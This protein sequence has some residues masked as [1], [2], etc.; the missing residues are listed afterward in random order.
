MRRGY[1]M[2]QHHAGFAATAAQ[3]EKHMLGFD[4]ARRLA[5]CAGWLLLLMASSA[6][7][8][9]WTVTGSG[10]PAAAN[11]NDCS[12][13]NCATLRGA[14][15]AAQNGDTIQFASA[16][17]GSTITLTLGTLTVSQSIT[18]TGPGAGQLTVSGNNAV[19]VFHI[20]AVGTVRISGLKIANGKAPRGGAID[21]GNNATLQLDA[22]IIANNTSTDTGGGGGGLNAELGSGVTIT[23]STF[24]SNSAS[25]AGGAILSSAQVTIG[26]TTFQ[27]NRATTAGGAISNQPT[28]TLSVTNST[29]V[30]NEAA[31]SGAIDNQHAPITIS[32]STFSANRASCCYAGAIENYD[33]NLTVS[34]SIFSSNTS[35]NGAGAVQS[36]GGGTMDMANSAYNLFYGNKNNGTEDDTTGYGTA[37]YVYT[38]TAPLGALANNGGPTQ[39]ML[40]V[41]GSAAIDR[42]APGALCPSA[43]QRGGPRPQ[44]DLCDIGAVEVQENQLTL[45]IGGSGSVVATPAPNGVSAFNPCSGSLCT[46]WYSAEGS[47][48]PP[49]V[50]LVATAAV[51]NAIVGWNGDCTGTA[52]SASVTMNVAHGCGV[53]FNAYTVVPTTLP[54][55]TYGSPYAQSLTAGGAGT[56][57][58]TLQSGSS[59]PT[60]MTLTAAGVVLGTPTQAGDF[61]FTVIATDENGSTTLPTT[62]SL[63]IGKAPLTITADNQSRAYGTADPPFTWTPSGFVND[64]TASALSG[65]PTLSS[66]DTPTSSAGTTFPITIAQGTLAAANYN[67]TFVN[68]TLS[69]VKKTTTLTLAVTPNPMLVNTSVAI[70]ATVVGDPPS[71]TVTFCDGS[72]TPDAVCTGGTLLCTVTLTAGTS[73]STA[74]CTHAFATTG[75]HPLGAYYAGDG[76]FV[77]TATVQ[78]LALSVN[79]PPIPAPA[80]ST[81]LLG[82]LGSLLVMIG[83]ARA[84]NVGA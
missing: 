46:A 47:G 70:V 9:T 10:E 80:L 28:G 50:M 16:V 44:G 31:M 29:F 1:G 23:N 34:G 79:P 55:G 4:I 3:T 27:N 35:G 60:G 65:A 40:P 59:L 84:R 66:T 63:H 54:S 38:T 2:G 14:I 43:D 57:I 7:A 78:A 30:G 71:G 42:I 45:V 49:N 26:T 19:Q 53:S 74:T 69:I 61:T 77:A 24:D 6:G 36:N 37:N 68:G 32:N 8:S 76:N 72:T 67:F 12:G 25:F 17:N 5:H 20:A 56:S 51:G 75:T 64:D 22:C 81:W 11:T 33:G 82:L 41:A 83:L 48:A 21:N 18:I 62:I 73:N 15:N 58:Y 52:A 39:T 13:G